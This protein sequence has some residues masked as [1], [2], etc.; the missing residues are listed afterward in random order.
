MINYMSNRR[1]MI[2]PLTVGLIKMIL[3][4]KIS[5]LSEPYGRSKN[6]IKI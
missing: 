4:C 3:V 1:A 6:K 2:M 5:Y